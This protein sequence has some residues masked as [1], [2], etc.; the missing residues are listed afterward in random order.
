M[1]IILKRG[2]LSSFSHSTTIQGRNLISPLEEEVLP[3]GSGE[4]QIAMKTC[5]PN[6]KKTWHAYVYLSTVISRKAPNLYEMC[7]KHLC[8]Y[9]NVH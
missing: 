7:L 8:L 5:R 2:Q 4:E 1:G 9:N 6:S 3:T